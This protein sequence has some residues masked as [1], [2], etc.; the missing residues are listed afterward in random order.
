M[1]RKSDSRFSDKIMLQQ[2]PHQTA[3][4]A[5]VPVTLRRHIIGT[6]TPAMTK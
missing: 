2:R 1:I 6:L 4:A 5:R 3:K